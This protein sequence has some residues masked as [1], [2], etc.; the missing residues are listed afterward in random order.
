MW[1]NKA[2]LS[3]SHLRLKYHKSMKRALYSAR[4]LPS[5]SSS[6][7]MRLMKALLSRFHPKLKYH[8]VMKRDL[9]RARKYAS[10]NFFKKFNSKYH[11][12]RHVLHYMLLNKVRILTLLTYQNYPAGLATRLQPQ[13]N[14]MIFTLYQ[15][16][17]QED[18]RRISLDYENKNIHFS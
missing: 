2:L 4:N 8:R 18:Q 11:L 10:V 9:Y 5:A 16:S 12:L 17:K 7:S 6:T 1:M 13:W 15:S 3:R 14:F